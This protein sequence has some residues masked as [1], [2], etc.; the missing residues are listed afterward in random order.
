MY[1]RQVWVYLSKIPPTYFSTYPIEHT[2]ERKLERFFGLSFEI[3]G[4]LQ[5]N[6]RNADLP[7]YVNRRIFGPL[8]LYR[9]C[10]RC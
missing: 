6:K 1:K 7:A 4:V 2:L 5:L 9:C 10:C 8:V 3:P